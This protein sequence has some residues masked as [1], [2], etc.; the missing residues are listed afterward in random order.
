MKKKDVIQFLKTFEKENKDKYHILGI[1]V[2]GSVARDDV[3]SDSDIDVVVKLAKQD[4]FDIIGIRQDLKEILNSPVDV[5]SYRDK[6]NSFL[7][8]RIDSE[9]IYV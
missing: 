2:F 1:G 3:K 7:K 8:K 4:L 6:M 9:A 5:V